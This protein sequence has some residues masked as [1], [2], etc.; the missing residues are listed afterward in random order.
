VSSGRL[1]SWRVVAAAQELARAGD[2]VVL[3]IPDPDILVPAP[4]RHMTQLVYVGDVTPARGLETMLEVLSHLDN[5][6]TL[7]VI[8]RAGTD[9]ATT[10]RSA[11]QRLGVTERVKVTGRLEHAEAWSLAGGSLA[12]LNLLS[13]APAYLNAIA[14][15]VW[16]YMAI[17]LPPVVTDLPGQARLVAN[18]DG[19]LVC[20]SPKEV[21]AVVRRLGEDRV[22]WQRVSDR[23]RAL[24]EEAW[25]EHRPD[26]VIQSTIRP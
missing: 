25:G 7:L 11:A 17:G 24:V 10:L 15:K 4:L 6:F 14:T 1:A 3:N 16:E 23:G 5:S 21:A 19:A 13:A 20:Q 8:G 9:A 2:A 22:F 12:G 18:I 26:I